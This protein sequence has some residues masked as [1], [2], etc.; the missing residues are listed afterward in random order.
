MRWLSA[1]LCSCITAMPVERRSGLFGRVVD[2][3]SASSAGFCLGG[4]GCGCGCGCGRLPLRS[5]SGLAGGAD[6]WRA[7]TGLAGGGGSGA[8]ACAWLA[9]G[10]LRRS[11]TKR[12]C[13]SAFSELSAATRALAALA[14]NAS[15]AMLARSTH[16][17]TVNSLSLY[18]RDRQRDDGVSRRLPVEARRG[19]GAGA[20]GKHAPV[21]QR[22]C[23]RAGGSRGGSAAPTR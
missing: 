7:R 9:N 12:I 21:V 10:A 16:S 23:W 6:G 2:F 4:C 17:A 3:V 5:C 19:G 8:S 1:V 15:M 18:R 13:G 11:V 20:L 22:R 14:S